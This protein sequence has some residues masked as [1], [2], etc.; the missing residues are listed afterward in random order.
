MI[1]EDYQ[2]I[3]QYTTSEDDEEVVL[4]MNEILNVL[5]FNMNT[6]AIYWYYWLDKLSQLK[7]KDKQVIKCESRKITQIKD[8]YWKDWVWILWNILLDHSRKAGR[9]EN[10]L[11][12]LYQM[13][14][15]NFNL[16]TRKTKHVIISTAILF[17]KYDMNDQL[18]WKTPVIRNYHLYIQSIGNINFLY[19][20]VYYKLEKNFQ[21]EPLFQKMKT[22]KIESTQ[23]KKFLKQFQKEFSQEA[24]ESNIKTKLFTELI[25]YQDGHKTNESIENVKKTMKTELPV[26]EYNLIRRTK[27]HQPPISE[28]NILEYYQQPNTESSEKI[29]N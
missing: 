26:I 8:T 25:T 9:V 23:Y 4:A 24:R 13:Y 19:Q 10:H 17:V 29:I 7:K 15:H 3:T 16:T 12:I 6:S 18:N 21:T 14:K 28:K 11:K 5:K 1:A 20:D 27:K 22:L 2:E